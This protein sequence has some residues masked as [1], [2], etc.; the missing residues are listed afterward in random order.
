M[1]QITALCMHVSILLL[2]DGRRKKCNFFFSKSVPHS[3]ICIFTTKK[4]YVPLHYSTSLKRHCRSSRIMK[5]IQ[6]IAITSKLTA[7]IGPIPIYVNAVKKPSFYTS[8]MIILSIP[9]FV[10]HLPDTISG[11]SNSETCPVRILKTQSEASFSWSIVYSS[12]SVSRG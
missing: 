7:P 3:I 4:Y 9:P 2:Y 11:T 6:I 12:S 1:G 5:K 10:H 8:M